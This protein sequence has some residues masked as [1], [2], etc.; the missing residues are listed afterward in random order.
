MCNPEWNVSNP[1][2]NHHTLILSRWL[3]MLFIHKRTNWFHFRSFW[4]EG[5]LAVEPIAASYRSNV[6]KVIMSRF[7]PVLVWVHDETRGREMCVQVEVFRHV[8]HSTAP[9]W[10]FASSICH[11]LSLPLPKINWDGWWNCELGLST[12]IWTFSGLSSLCL[13]GIFLKMGKCSISATSVPWVLSLTQNRKKKK[14]TYVKSVCYC[15]DSGWNA[16]SASGDG[17]FCLLA[18]AAIWL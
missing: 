1:Q 12:D 18:S 5:K 6:D 14:V 13:E 16:A 9:S 4:P 10:T 3:R 17:Y 8:T 2:E 15:L 7:F 11:L